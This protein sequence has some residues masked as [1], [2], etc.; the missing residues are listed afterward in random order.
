[1]EFSCNFRV[2]EI[3]M[4]WKKSLVIKHVKATYHYGNTTWKFKVIYSSVNYLTLSLSLG[5]LADS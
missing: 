5:V 3:I 1:M 2:F 4:K